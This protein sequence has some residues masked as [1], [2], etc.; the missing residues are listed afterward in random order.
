M[1]LS[2]CFLPMKGEFLFMATVNEQVVTG[3]A[4]RVLI[5]KASK[6]WQK[7]SFWTKA[8][9]VEFSDGNTAETKVGAITGITSSLNSTSDN[10]ALSASA[11]KAI[12][13]SLKII[14]STL[15]AGETS[16]TISEQQITT[17]SALS[18]YTSIYGVNPKDVSVVDGSVTLTF[19]A[20][21]AAMTVGVRIDG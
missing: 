15:A 4:H 19:D 7:I 5:D 21:S 14:T 12:N 17:N 16:I 2:K 10:M 9:D 1:H 6:L 18:F 3:R 20:Q 8:S 11:G 13:D